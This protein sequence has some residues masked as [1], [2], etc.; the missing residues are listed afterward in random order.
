MKEHFLSFAAAILLAVPAFS[1]GS[2][3][4]PF[5]RVDRNP[6]TSAFAGGGAAHN[7]TAAYSAFSGAAMLPFYIG[8]MD[9]GL[10]F[11]RWAPG[12]APS[13]NFSIG[14]AWKFLPK[15][16]VSLGYTLENE[17]P[18]E[19]FPAPGEPSGTFYPK[20]H[21][22]AFGAGFGLGERFSIG[23]NVRYAREVVMVNRIYGGVAADLFG[24]FQPFPA[25]RI[26][27]GLANLGTNVTSGNHSSSQP[28]SVLAAADWSPAL[29]PDHVLHV[30]A[31][32]NVYLAGDYSATAALEYSWA[33]MLFVRAGY[34]LASETCVIPSH[35]ALG[36]GVRFAG[37]RADLSYLTASPV[38][39]NTLNIGLGYSF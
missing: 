12:L 35:L 5:T 38:I 6:V 34:R 26:T 28:A 21:V 8:S 18:Y 27:A 25:L 37:F 29:A 1:Q 39:G 9:A 3:A 11:Q 31:D 22:V 30:M 16:G 33:Q 19:V 13:S 32:L 4:L 17:A 10:S 20:N 14:A 2:D 15:M 24:A 23:L 36:L 7:G